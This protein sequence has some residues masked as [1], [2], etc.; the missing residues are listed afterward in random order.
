MC[1]ILGV[2]RGSLDVLDLLGHCTVTGESDTDIS[3]EEIGF[4]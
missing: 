2:R 3:E 1:D 4:I